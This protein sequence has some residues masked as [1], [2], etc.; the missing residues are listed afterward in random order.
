ML[1]KS[2]RAQAFWQDLKSQIAKA[3]ITN[4]I[5]CPISEISNKRQSHLIVA[6][7]LFIVICSLNFIWGLIFD[8][9]ST[10]LT[11]GLGFPACPVG[12]LIYPTGLARVRTN[13]RLLK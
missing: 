6:V 7:V 3:Q 2:I 10:W 13:I 11:T 4:K 1:D 8:M 12:F 5:Q 9:D